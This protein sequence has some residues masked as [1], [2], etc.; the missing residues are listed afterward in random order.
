[1]INVYIPALETSAGEK[2]AR[3]I[4]TLTKPIGSL[5]RLEEIAVELAAMT[6]E[7]FPTVTPP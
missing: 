1:M 4:D 3:Y 2:A 5:G 7:V 6:G